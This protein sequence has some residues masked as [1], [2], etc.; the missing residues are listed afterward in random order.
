MSHYFVYEL[1]DPTTSRSIFVGV[2]EGTIEP[3]PIPEDILL[4]DPE[5]EIVHHFVG[6]NLTYDD[7]IRLQKTIEEMNGFTSEPF[8]QKV[9]YAT[10][11]IS[12]DMHSQIKNYCRRSGLHIGR[13]VELL[14]QNHITGSV[15]PY[16]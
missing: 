16:E 3:P 4:D 13:F 12:K 9:Q 11:Q 2:G 1:I 10:V 15:L 6:Q 5:K 8:P 7:A 14:F